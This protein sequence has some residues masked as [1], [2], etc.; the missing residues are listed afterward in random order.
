MKA[1]GTEVNK[2]MVKKWATRSDCSD[3]MFVR[4]LHSLG[5][6]VYP[7]YMKC[8]FASMCKKCAV[9]EEHF[10]NICNVSLTLI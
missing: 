8:P 2:I 6:R 3:S 4:K 10:V 7:Q 9:Y 5:G 1:P